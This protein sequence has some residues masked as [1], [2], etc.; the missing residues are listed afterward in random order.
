MKFY[1]LGAIY[2]NRVR[3]QSA[4]PTNGWVNR[5]TEMTMSNVYYAYLPTE[6]GSSAADRKG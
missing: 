4:C 6:F 1:S 3:Y 2:W 5:R